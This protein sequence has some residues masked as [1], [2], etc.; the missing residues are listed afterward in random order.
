M[1]C[2]AFVAVLSL[3]ILSCSK[4]KDL[5]TEVL[6]ETVWKVKTPDYQVSIVFA[7][8]NVFAAVTYVYKTKKT[9]VAH[10]RFDCKKNNI[11]LTAKGI[12]WT[13]VVDGNIMTLTAGTDQLEL[14]RI[15]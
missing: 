1:L 3:T 5:A 12:N 4:E 13:G 8:Q 9:T 2:L 11:T 10:G 7:H 6:P 15:F 14:K